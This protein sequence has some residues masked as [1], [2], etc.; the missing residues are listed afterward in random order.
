MGE[1]LWGIFVP[2]SKKAIGAL[3]V[4]S[5]IRNAPQIVSGKSC[6]HVSLQSEARCG[7]NGISYLSQ[8]VFGRARRVLLTQKHPP[9]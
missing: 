4:L 9:A 5:P 7:C 8:S 6:F 1:Y 2:P 3:A